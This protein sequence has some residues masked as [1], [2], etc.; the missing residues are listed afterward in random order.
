MILNPLIFTKKKFV[1]TSTMNNDIISFEYI[2]AM[3]CKLYYKE[4]FSIE[5]YIKM[6]NFRSKRAKDSIP[7]SFQSKKGKKKRA[8]LSYR[9]RRS[10]EREADKVKEKE[11]AKYGE[12]D[13]DILPPIDAS[14][15]ILESLISPIREDREYGK[16]QQQKAL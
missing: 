16:S 12:E 8:E 6:F 10:S 4:S 14:L 7:K 3:V 5:D 2:L 15:D 1:K 9:R 11:K 13:Y